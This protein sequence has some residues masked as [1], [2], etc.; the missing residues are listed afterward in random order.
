MEKRVIKILVMGLI[1]FV[2]KFL[3][4][5]GVKWERTVQVMGS[6]SP[7][8][9]IFLPSDMAFDGKGNVFVADLKGCFVRKYSLGGKILA[10]AGRKGNGPGEFLAP[11]KL[12]YTEGKL[13]V[14]D[15]RARRLSVFDERLKFLTSYSLPVNINDFFIQDGK[16][17]A[18]VTMP[19]EPYSLA[20]IG[21]D[22]KIQKKF[23]DR[24]PVYLKGN[25]KWLFLLKVRYGFLILG[26][27][28]DLKELAATFRGYEDGNDLYLLSPAGKLRKKI[29]LNIFNGYKFP[30]DLLKVLQKPPSHTR[31]VYVKAL[32]LLDD[33]DIL[34]TLGIRNQEQGRV[35]SQ[36]TILA[37][38]G[39]NGE[40]KGQKKLP[41][42][43]QTYE[44]R[45]RK[46]L[47]R[48]FENEDEIFEIWSLK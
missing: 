44:V 17:F 38:L 7:Q 12:Y 13:Y 2:V 32:H 15:L 46:L 22:G 21:K 34:L 31:V 5:G 4:W 28:P 47:I 45:K 18:S 35:V 24:L 26:Y 1:I 27:N 16:I 42:F 25:E 41:G 10:E 43:W 29:P 6:G 23:F 30:R 20:I 9:V 48:N 37:V 36:E 39:S 40:L 3:L 19:H 33:G 11:F 8:E 14:W